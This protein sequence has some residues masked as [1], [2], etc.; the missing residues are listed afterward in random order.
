MVIISL[1]SISIRVF[2]FPMEDLS[3][4]HRTTRFENFTGHLVGGSD[5][6]L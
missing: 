5:P 6:G 1:M 3:S 2:I 4:P